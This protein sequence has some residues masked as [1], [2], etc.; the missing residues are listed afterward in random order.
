M[1]RI[2]FSEEEK[3][4][5]HYERFHHPHPR[6]QQRMEALWLKSRNL[7]H[8]QIAD[9][10]QVDEDTLRG[11]LRAYQEGGIERLK[12]LN[13]RGSWGALAGHADTLRIFFRN[14]LRLPWPRRAPRSPS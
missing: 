2:E 11:Y 4:A 8:G 1:L 10:V 12:D 9:L 7:P 3:Q 14:I 6:V 13:W 5:L